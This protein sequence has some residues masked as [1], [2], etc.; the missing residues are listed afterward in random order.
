MTTTVRDARFR[1]HDRRC[2]GLLCSPSESFT[3]APGLAHYKGPS[4]VQRHLIN[5][6]A[7]ETW[8]IPT[9][10]EDALAFPENRLFH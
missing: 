8:R 10:L 3:Y 9:V 2:G 6:L 7:C 5:V 4:L 1:L